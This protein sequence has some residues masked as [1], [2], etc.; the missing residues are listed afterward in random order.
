MKISLR[1][2]ACLQ[3]RREF[4]VFRNSDSRILFINIYL[5]LLCFNDM[6]IE[7]SDLSCGVISPFCCSLGSFMCDSVNNPVKCSGLICE[8]S[9]AGVGKLQVLGSAGFN[10][11]SKGHDSSSWGETSTT[12]SSNRVLNAILCQVQCDSSHSVR[13][14]NQC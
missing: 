14:S 10:S 6:Q 12:P 11:P 7:S 9:L 5:L 8:I 4:L 3:C 1:L 2:A 13:S